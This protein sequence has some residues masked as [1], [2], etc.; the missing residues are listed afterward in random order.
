MALNFQSEIL[1]QI[2]DIS[3]KIK[4]EKFFS[5]G[6]NLEYHDCPNILKSI[7]TEKVAHVLIDLESSPNAFSLGIE[8]S[9]TSLYSTE[10][11]NKVQINSNNSVNSICRQLFVPRSVR[12]LRLPNQLLK[13]LPMILK[14]FRK[15]RLVQKICL[16]LSSHYNC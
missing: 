4:K 5:F 8:L 10:F 11:S 16:H 15:V 9:S 13:I 2:G 14:N 3:L 6:D 12:K 7:S 1:S